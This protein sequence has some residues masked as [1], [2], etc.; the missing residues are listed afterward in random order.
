MTAKVLKLGCALVAGLNIAA[1]AVAP[2]WAIG[3]VNDYPTATRADYIFGCMQVNGNNKLVLD[4][5]ACSIDVIASLVPHEEYVEAETVMGYRL[6]GGETTAPM[7]A[8]A[9]KEKVHKLK[10]AQ[11]EGELK[12]F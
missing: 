7:F 4:K 5:C 9:M 2:A 8:Q 1:A 6:K 12:C 10:L 3:A 11:V